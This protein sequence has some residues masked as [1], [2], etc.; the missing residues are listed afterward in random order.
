MY[1][2]SDREIQ[3]IYRRGEVEGERRFSMTYSSHSVM[4]K[5]KL[6]QI[7]GIVGAVLAGIGLI[8]FVLRVTKCFRCLRKKTST[9]DHEDTE[10]ERDRLMR[11]RPPTGESAENSGLPQTQSSGNSSSSPQNNQNGVTTPDTNI[12]IDDHAHDSD[13]DSLH[14]MNELPPSYESLYLNEQGEPVTP[15]KYSPPEHISTHPPRRVNTVN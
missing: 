14:D 5:E 11:N 1:V 15:P 7:A 10:R 6:I 2:S 9:D 8:Y 4:S 12:V 3:V 13:I